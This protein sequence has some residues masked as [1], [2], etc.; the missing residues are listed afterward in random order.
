MP[1]RID[2]AELREHQLRAMQALQRLESLAKA[3]DQRLAGMHQWKAKLVI[4]RDAQRAG[5]PARRTFKWTVSQGKMVHYTSSYRVAAPRPLGPPPKVVE[6]IFWLLLPGKHRQA[7][8]GDAAEAYAETLK[9]YGRGSA[10]FDYCKEALFATIASMRMSMAQW[11]E[12]LLKR[13]S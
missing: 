12:L 5:E 8:M 13:S 6:M 3:T 4:R 9:R 7:I 1:K 11:I 10:T 2:P